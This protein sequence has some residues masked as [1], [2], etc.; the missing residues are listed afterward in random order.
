[1]LLRSRPNPLGFIKP[2]APVLYEVA[3]AGPDWLHEIKHDGWRMI[4]RKDGNSVRLWSRNG[5]DWTADFP[6]IVTAIAH[7]PNDRLVLD[8]RRLGTPLTAC[9]TST[10]CNRL[11]GAWRGSLR[12]RPLGARRSG[13]PP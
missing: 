2:C 7:L 4:A 6:G 5:R 8:A 13:S 1:M 11:R 9:L 12:L 10:P 3:P